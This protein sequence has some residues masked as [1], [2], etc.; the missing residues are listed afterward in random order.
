MNNYRLEI[1]KLKTE[2]YQL[3]RQTTGWDPIAEEVVG[4]ALENDLFSVCVFNDEKMIGMGR[5]LG[6]GAI[7]FY[8]QDVIVHPD[9]HG[10]GIGKLIMDSIEEYLKK[11]TNQ[12]SFVGLMA[13]E[14]VKDFYKKYGYQER[15]A[16]RPGMFKLIKK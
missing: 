11:T 9:F 4:K 15:P 12:N 8:I 6:D 14:G 5:V 16:G 3:L 2:E 7:Y 10:R 13:A 1:R